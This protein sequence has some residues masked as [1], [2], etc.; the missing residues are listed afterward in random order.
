M[1]DL[2]IHYVHEINDPILASEIISGSLFL[3]YTRKWGLTWRFIMFYC[4]FTYQ[5]LSAIPLHWIFHVQWEDQLVQQSI[6]TNHLKRWVWF[7]FGEV[8]TWNLELDRSTVSS[9]IMPTR[10]VPGWILFS[11]GVYVDGFVHI[12][13]VVTVHLHEWIQWSMLTWHKAWVDV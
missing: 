2:A 5:Q 10:H 13:G 3:L 8:I 6:V 4:N 1:Q 11:K 12:R 7:L 9:S